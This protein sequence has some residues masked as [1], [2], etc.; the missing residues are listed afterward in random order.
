VAAISVA[1]IAGYNAF[2]LDAVG[3]AADQ[4]AALNLGH[5]QLITAI[6]GLVALLGS[7]RLVARA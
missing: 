5:G 3:D 7:A 4:I 2:N 1:A 6:G